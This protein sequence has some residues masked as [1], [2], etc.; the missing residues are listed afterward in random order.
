MSELAI[1][2][3]VGPV[4]PASAETLLRFQ[5]GRQ[6]GEEERAGEPVY[7]LAAPTEKLK[8]AYQAALTTR[9]FKYPSDAELMSEIRV[10]LDDMREVH[11]RDPEQ[12]IT[13]A[14][15]DRR[16]TDLERF[17]ERQVQVLEDARRK[18]QAMAAAAKDGGADDTALTAIASERLGRA[19]QLI[20]DRYQ[21]LR[22]LASEHCPG[23]Q[24]M[25][26][27][28]LRYVEAYQH[29]AACVALRGWE[30]RVGDVVVVGTEASAATMAQLD[31]A[32][33]E[34]IGTYWR[35]QSTLT[36]AQKK[37]SALPPPS[38][39][40]PT[41]TPEAGSSHPS[42]TDAAGDSRPSRA[43]KSGTKSTTPTRVT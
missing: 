29:V 18:I 35:E 37:T 26:Q 1:N 38:P 39:T 43:T 27:Q 25:E 6:D 15:F 7:L 21:Q 16:M 32:T 2:G 31:D 10:W 13:E 20:V 12:G 33:Q 4:I 11:E 14:T 8:R 9:G 24:A 40:I 23:V 36:E 42:S 17:H 41:T 28:R 19:D 34:Q 3:S 5:P 22:R 30:G